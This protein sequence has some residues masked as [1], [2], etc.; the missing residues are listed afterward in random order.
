M[1][2]KIK[3][4]LIFL[5]SLVLL[6]L[7]AGVFYWFEYRPS[8]IREECSWINKHTEAI[9]EQPTMNEAQLKEKGLITDCSNWVKP[10][11]PN[12]PQDL[13]N[14]EKRRNDICGSGNQRI[15]EKYSK[16]TPAIPA[17]DWS[18]KASTKEYE[19]CIKSKGINH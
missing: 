16:S 8:K 11:D 13:Q 10:I 9:P 6:T 12:L 1:S 18:E 19:F 5:A 3:V 2:V 15:I 4:L 17:K 14:F 7:I